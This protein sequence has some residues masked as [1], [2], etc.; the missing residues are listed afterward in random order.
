M[1]SGEFFDHFAL[2]GGVP[3]S[4]AYQGIAGTALFDLE[5]KYHAPKPPALP[6]ALIPDFGYS[7][8]LQMWSNMWSKQIFDL[9]T[10]GKCSRFKRCVNGLR[11]LE[12][13][14]WIES[15]ALPNQARY[16]LRYTRIFT[17]LP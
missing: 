9:Y 1:W 3:V 8:L 11:R 15:A 14:S 16:Q 4:Q 17:F 13:A 12:N 2:R 10:F 6:T 7:I 5:G